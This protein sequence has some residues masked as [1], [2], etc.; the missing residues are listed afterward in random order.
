MYGSIFKMD[1]CCPHIANA[2]NGALG[3]NQLLDNPDATEIFSL[4][5]LM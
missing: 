2:D 1:F 3:K 4:K 5:K